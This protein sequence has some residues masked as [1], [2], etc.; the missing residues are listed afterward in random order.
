MKR[1]LILLFV[2]I[3]IYAS[4]R[5]ADN[6][7][8]VDQIGDNSIVTITQDGAGHSATVKLGNMSMV[9]AA[10]MSVVQ[11]GLGLKT[12]NTEIKSGFNNVMSLTQ[13]GAGN[14]TANLIT[15]GSYNTTNASQTGNANHQ[16]DVKLTGNWNSA[17]V[18]QSGNT[19]NMAN[20]DLT[21]AGGPA[22][23]NL[24][25]TGGQTFSLIQ[26]CSNPMGCSTT[27]RQP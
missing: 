24:T 18:N 20:I 7:I 23:I 10:T 1:L 14:H 6:M 13:D 5:A 19:A 16:L 21:N 17:T 26:V 8:D 4:A 2:G 22:T 15:L 12:A 9:D 11:Q 27:V 3:V 25:Q